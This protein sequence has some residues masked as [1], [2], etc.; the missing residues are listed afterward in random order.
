[1]W[2]VIKKMPFD[3]LKLYS[4]SVGCSYNT[5]GDN[6]K[7]IAYIWPMA[8]EE[9]A[10]FWQHQKITSSLFARSIPLAQVSTHTNTAYNSKLRINI[11]SFE[12]YSGPFFK[13]Y[14]VTYVLRQTDHY[15]SNLYIYM[16]KKLI[17]MMMCAALY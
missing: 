9:T 15:E 2:D 4:D 13:I 6:R 14:N 1:M 7:I 10:S 16:W 5:N 11:F 3:N 12:F 8:S 17:I